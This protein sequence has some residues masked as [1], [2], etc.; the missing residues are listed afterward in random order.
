V[1]L[2]EA[3]YL[4]FASGGA[5]TQFSHEYQTLT[6]AG[7]DTIYIDEDKKI[8]INE[9]VLTDEVIKQ[10]GTDRKKLKKAKAAEV[11]N[12]FSFGAVKSDQ[13]DLG[14]DGEDGKTRP[15]ILGSYGI[16]VT[17]LIGVIVEHFADDKGLVWPE[18][19]A[20][21]Q[22][23]IARLGE[24]E[25]VVAAADELFEELRKNNISVIYDDRDVRPGQK[26]ADADLLGIPRR[27]VV[28][29]KTLEKNKIEMKYR[30]GDKPDFLAPNELIT[31][32]SGSKNK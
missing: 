10:L 27:A 32:L 12:I 17:R 5:F 30:T 20:P 4:T 28:S 22:V 25:K 26:F 2:G 9:E 19:I 1:G 21:A 24:S 31:R 29:E 8:A 23:Y 13:L 15:V 18:D 16:G 7:E 14:Y 11:G 6:D 3:T